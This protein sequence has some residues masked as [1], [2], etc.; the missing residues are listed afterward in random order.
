MMNENRGP[1]FTSGSVYFQRV[2]HYF[3]GE[4]IPSLAI[5]EPSTLIS[6]AGLLGSFFVAG[7]ILKRKLN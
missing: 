6:A 4:T 2:F 5:E 3:R 7:L 1:S